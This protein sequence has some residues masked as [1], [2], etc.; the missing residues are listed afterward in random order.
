MACIVSIC[1]GYSNI[2][3]KLRRIN[4]KANDK[5]WEQRDCKD[6]KNTSKAMHKM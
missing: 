1:R 6:L 4:R 3:V 2:H 5:T